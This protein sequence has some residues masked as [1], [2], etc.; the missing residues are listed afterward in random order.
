MMANGLCITSPCG[1]LSFR[2]VE[3]L[4]AFERPSRSPD[5]VLLCSKD[6][7]HERPIS[8]LKPWV[9]TKSQLV[10]LHSGQSHQQANERLLAT[11]F[12]ENTLISA[13]PH[14]ALRRLGPHSITHQGQGR[15][16][17]GCYPEGVDDRCRL[18]AGYLRA[19]GVEVEIAEWILTARWR[20]DAWNA[21]MAPLAALASGS[22]NDPANTRNC[23]QL[24]RQ[25]AAETL[26]V[27]A[28]AGHTTQARS[29]DAHIAAMRST[30]PYL[31]HVAE[32]QTA[33]R[34]EDIAAILDQVANKAQRCGVAVPHL[35]TLRARLR[36][37]AS[38][39]ISHT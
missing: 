9:A 10:L 30:A 12:P 21:S 24:L 29:I 2:P 28:A 23:E 8:H 19:G 32:G 5:Y 17:L 31:T 35:Q 15:I 16:V 36:L 26:A 1:D 3:V 34:P 25:L 4:R 18:L 7:Q 22:S 13:L 11:A 33:E 39:A 20:H 14:V 6:L 38:H 27:A 37:R